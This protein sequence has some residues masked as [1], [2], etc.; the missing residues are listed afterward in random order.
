MAPVFIVG[1]PRS[2]TSMLHWSLAQHSQL[3]GSAESDFL[4]EWVKGTNQAWA[5]GNVHG[6][7]H[8]LPKEKVSREEFFGFA[9]AGIDAMYRSRS[10]GKRWLEKTPRNVFLYDS[11]R[12]MFPG[13]RFI[14]IVRD[15]RQAVDSMQRKFGLPFARCLR[16]WKRHVSAGLEASRLGYGD[17]LQVHYEDLVRDSLCSMNAVFDFIGEELESACLEFLKQPINTA[18][19]RERES[20]L[21]KLDSERVDWDFLRAMVFRL[22]CGSL[23]DSLGYGR[24]EKPKA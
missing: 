22:T 18:P 6:E 10:E 16:T 15:G 13:A 20:S 2:G 4:F 9:G 19:G 24:D 17:L 8:W 11:L 23:Q 12:L 3:W 14:H 21:Q 1:S 5:A 7:L